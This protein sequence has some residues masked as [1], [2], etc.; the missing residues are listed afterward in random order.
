MENMMFN[1]LWKMLTRTPQVASD[2]LDAIASGASDAIVEKAAEAKAK[3]KI[4]KDI[5]KMTKAKIEEHGREL[6]IE[7]DRRMTKPNMIKDLKSK[8]K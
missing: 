7:L 5:A 4:A 8:L 3:V 1:K 2:T 6:G